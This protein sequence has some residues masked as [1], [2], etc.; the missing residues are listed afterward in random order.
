MRRL[1]SGVLFLAVS[2]GPT[3]AGTVQG[4]IRIGGSG[5]PAVR[6]T[7]FLDDLT[8]F[9]EVRTAADGGYMIP[10]VPN[11]TYRLGVALRGMEYQQ[12][13]V[14]VGAGV[15]TRDFTLGPETSPGRWDIV[16]STLPEFFDATDI[17]IL[18]PDGR[19]MFCHDTTD[20]IIYDPATQTNFA[21]AGSW[22]EQGCMNA[23]LLQDGRVIMV[24]GQSP[25]DPGSFRNAVNW[26]K[27]YNP[28]NNTWAP[29]PFM[30]APNGRWYPGMCRLNDAS[31]LVMG[32]GTA[33]NAA[34]TATT[35]RYTLGAPA[36]VNSGNMLNP[37]EFTPTALLHTGEVL[38]TWSPPQLY[39]PTSG[40]FR[41][42]GNFTQPNR[43]WP[44]HS[45]H[46]I[47]VLADGRVVALGIRAGANDYTAMSEVY[48]PATGQWT[49]G[50]SPA[51]RRYQAEVVQLPDGRTLVAAGDTGS[52]NPGVPHTLGVVKWSDLYDPEG[53]PGGT[54]RRMA[55]MNWFREYHAVTLLIPDGRVITTGGTRIK[56]QVG[57]TSADIEGFVPPYL[58]R[59]VRPQITS[60]SATRLERGR[61]V[62]MAITPATTLTSAVLVSTG[63]H[64]H[65][66][67][68]GTQRRVVLPVAQTGSAAEIDIPQDP[69]LLPAGYYM[70]F[71]MVDD[72]PSVARIVQ[73][74]TGCSSD[75]NGDGDF[76]TDQDIEAFFA[77]LGSAC[78]PTCLTADFNGDGD[79]G[80]DQDIEAFFRVL[81]GGP[82]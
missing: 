18:L 66:V 81:S 59:G 68:T 8:F 73:V 16:G 29:L 9:R 5:V 64:T 46:S 12:L 60:I 71:A 42:T 26:V 47:V 80:T 53:G 77:C 63:A 72:I 82:C 78:C 57:P 21:A 50:T 15:V 79:V 22:S 43:G 52:T 61:G 11:G 25:V 13:D 49:A 36:W 3:V 74:V 28:M 76:G 6:V 39:N 75:F 38:L 37:S 31:L 14:T 65:W 67:D 20:P 56:F 41:A 35:E 1:L 10:D 33:P 62:T 51:L 7:V 32:G 2:G 55:D 48:N 44:D 58:L 19:A 45:D 34:R 69:N 24:G 27:A 4:V 30:N 70:L 40:V 54:W 17:A 23:T